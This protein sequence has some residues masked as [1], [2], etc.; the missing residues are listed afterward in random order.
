MYSKASNKSRSSPQ[1]IPQKKPTW[2]LRNIFEEDFLSSKPPRLGF[3]AFQKEST[4]NQASVCKGYI[5]CKFSQE[6]YVY[7]P[8]KRSH[9]PFLKVRDLES[10][11]SS[12]K[13]PVW[14]V[15]YFWLG[16]LRAARYEALRSLGAG[17]GDLRC[18]Y[19]EE[20]MWNFLKSSW[21]WDGG[22]D[23]HPGS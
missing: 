1:I 21:F 17:E 3:H 7:P 11:V 23:Y 2:N 18:W 9:I 6:G 13:L 15:G 14:F 8:G 19:F 10:D 22:S 20:N 16:K 5:I 4:L 12:G